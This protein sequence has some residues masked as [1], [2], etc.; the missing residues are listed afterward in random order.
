MSIHRKRQ[1]QVPTNVNTV[2]D[3]QVVKYAVDDNKF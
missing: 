2:S 3:M 1:F